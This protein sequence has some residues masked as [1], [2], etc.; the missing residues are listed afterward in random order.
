MDHRDGMMTN[1][2]GEA[3]INDGK[4][5]RN[6]LRVP[7]S[8]SPDLWEDGK[9]YDSELAKK[10]EEV[11]TH[12]TSPKAPVENCC[13]EDGTA[14]TRHKGEESGLATAF[15]TEG[16]VS[17]YLGVNNMG[18]LQHSD[19]SS[20][21]IECMSE[22]SVNMKSIT[23]SPFL[24]NI[25]TSEQNS[26]FFEDGS[27]DKSTLMVPKEV[28]SSFDE[29]AVSIDDVSWAWSDG[30]SEG[31]AVMELDS[32]LSALESKASSPIPNDQKLKE[33]SM[34][35]QVTPQKMI[36]LI[37]GELINDK[38]RSMKQEMTSAMAS[39]PKDSANMRPKEPKLV[40]GLKVDEKQKRE[41]PIL[42]SSLPVKTSLLGTVKIKKKVDADVEPSITNEKS[43]TFDRI[44][45]SAKPR[46]AG[47][48]PD[49]GPRT[50]LSPIII[51]KKTLSPPRRIQLSPKPPLLLKT[52]SPIIKYRSPMSDTARSTG[53]SSQE[54]SKIS[55]NVGMSKAGNEKIL[56][57]FAESPSKSTVNY[58]SGLTNRKLRSVKKQVEAESVDRMKEKTL[59]VA[60]Q[61]LVG[62]TQK[63]TEQ[64]HMK[65]RS[66]QS[67][68]TLSSRSSIS[69]SAF[70]SSSCE[71]ETDG[72]RLT[73]SDASGS[74]KTHIGERKGRTPFHVAE[75]IGGAALKSAGQKHAKIGSQESS[76]NLSSRSSL[77]SSAFISSGHEEENDGS[78]LAI[79][80]GSGSK[81]VHISERKGRT[82][83]H[84]VEQERLGVALM[85]AEQKHT[86]LRSQLSSRTLSSRSSISSSPFVSSNYEE[87]NHKSS[88]SFTR[89]KTQIG[90]KNGR[91]PLHPP[92][93]DKTKLQKRTENT[94][95]EDKSS[96][97]NKM[98]FRRGKEVG[99][100]RE[101]HDQ[102]RLRLMQ[103]TEAFVDKNFE[104]ETRMKCF[105]KN[106]E[107]TT[108]CSG[109]V[110]PGSPTVVLW[111]QDVQEKNTQALSNDLIQETAK[112][113]VE[114][115]KSNVKALVGAFESIISRH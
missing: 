50:S 2:A 82:L 15:R 43:S 93:I 56:K 17:Y 1:L 77:S 53:Q 71:E 91:T 39:L 45:K 23:S 49:K 19:A 33:S 62:A 78:L 46:N 73:V 25:I 38:I 72:S 70:L 69:S 95:L 64:K 89:K 76:R 6:Y 35:F 41:L 54:S 106:S 111:Q 27:L 47:L 55:R 40:N 36:S 63:S 112:K 97:S 67:S 102:R 52:K 59:H 4:S 61:K 60:E 48:I 80:N 20:E 103:K 83:L 99:P 75:Q 3:D 115:R 5:P 94:I 16:D 104:G 98:P 8:S 34:E 9:K 14:Q 113:L 12:L 22:E 32:P 79:S 28:L 92:K 101:I 100:Q 13:P 21:L 107:S 57:Q 24:N 29:N 42:R 10:S 51:K 110:S 37:D 44:V 68:R 85:S 58:A 96:S 31:S 109:T 66:Q 114:V 105:R 81:K 65:L 11:P 86:K 88:P 87:E 108:V 30:F 7:A 90:D 18:H 26:S 74:K 84:V